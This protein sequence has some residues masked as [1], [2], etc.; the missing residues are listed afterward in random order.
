ME[1]KKNVINLNAVSEVTLGVIFKHLARDCGVIYTVG[2]GDEPAATLELVKYCHKLGLDIIAA[3]KGKNNPL[4]IYCNPDDFADIKEKTGVSSRSIASFV[5]GTKTM[6]E[7]AILSNATGFKIDRTGMHGPAVD[8]RDLHL[9]FCPQADGGILESIPAVDYAVGNVAPGVFVIF[10]S[11]QKSILDELNYLKMGPGP[12]YALY[13]PYHLG[14]IESPLS[15]FDVA[16]RKRPTLEVKGPFV[17]SVAGRA[18][19]TLKKGSRLDGAG[20]FTYS[21]V[22]VDHKLMAEKQYVP[23]GL[24]ENSDIIKDIEKDK[25]ISFGDIIPGKDS[26]VYRLWERQLRL[27]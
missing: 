14:N 20:G 12:Y 9:R 19:K 11:G 26:P 10:T 22:A 5:D 2:A 21:G 18:K 1:S 4:N 17:T 8:V 15:I 3:G 27:V 7:M 24:L 13:K 25:I 6:L 16:I 23:I